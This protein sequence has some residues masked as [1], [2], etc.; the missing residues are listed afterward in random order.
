VRTEV[1]VNAVIANALIVVRNE[2]RL[3]AEVT[4]HFGELPRVLCSKGELAQVMINLVMN[5]AHAVADVVGGTD[6]RGHI[7]ITTRCD[8]A[9]V[10]IAVSDTGTGVPEAIREQIF[11][12]FFTTKEVGKGT[13]QGLAITHAIVSRHR[14][15]ISLDTE[16]GRGTTFTIRLPIDD[17]VVEDAA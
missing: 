4:T 15:T 11:E 2:Y 17:P 3:V 13:G 5:A 14:G 8:G 9:E 10:V 16:L 7:D 12:P 6:D 1:D